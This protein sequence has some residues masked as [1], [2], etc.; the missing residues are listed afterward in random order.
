MSNF[1]GT[2]YFRRYKGVGLFGIRL[3]RGDRHRHVTNVALALTR[4]DDRLF[5]GVSL[6]RRPR[7]T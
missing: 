2:A 7:T 1:G 4:L 3:A 6:G 5:L